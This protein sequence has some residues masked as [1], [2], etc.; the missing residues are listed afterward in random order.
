MIP[1]PKTTS[2]SYKTKDCPGVTALTWILGSHKGITN[3]TIGQRK[4]LGISYSMPL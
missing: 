2:L 4:G 1:P 3:Y